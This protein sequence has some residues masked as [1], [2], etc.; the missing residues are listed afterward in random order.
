MKV[1]NC[2][3]PT[4]IRNKYSGE[5][6][7]VGCG[8]CKACLMKMSNKAAYLCQ[9]HEH[10]YKYCMFV[11]L[12]YDNENIPLMTYERIADSSFYAD[13][14][15]PDFD[16]TGFNSYESV[17]DAKRDFYLYEFNDCTPRL[18]DERGDFG[19]SMFQSYHSPFEMKML[20]SKFNLDG[21]FPYLN[22]R[23]LQLFIK[24]LRKQISRISNEK[25][26]HYSVGEYGPIHFRPHFHCLFYFNDEKIL[27]VFAQLVRSCWSFGRVDTQLSRG[28]CSSYVAKYVNSRVSVPRIFNH[29][30]VR[31]FALHSIHFA[32]RI[33]L[34]EKK[35]IYENAPSDF[36]HKFVDISSQ[37]VELYPWRS[38]TSLFFPK[39]KGYGRKSHDELSFTYRIL[40]TVRRLFGT[41]KEKFP[42]E[43]EKTISELA[44]SVVNEIVRGRHDAYDNINLWRKYTHSYVASWFA[45]ELNIVDLDELHRTRFMNGKRVLNDEQ[46]RV[47]NGIK[48][49]LYTSKHFLY[50]VCDNLSSYEIARKID[51]IQEFYEYVDY[52]NLVSWYQMQQT[53][54]ESDGQ[55]VLPYF[56]D[57]SNL[58][59]A[60]PLFSFG[61]Y[62]CFENDTNER[63]V[64]SIKHKQLNDLNNIF[65]DVPF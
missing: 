19:V 38:V 47:L 46:K 50:F 14:V 41:D 7:T 22:K 52:S 3:R 57:N 48:S 24:R 58:D 40:L 45:K 61:F 9:I 42:Y 29:N 62:K 5:M 51:K 37:V 15:T 65:C 39:C 20:A 27:Q 12:T 26:T 33:Y 64:R 10:D 28:K 18:M 4:R 32:Q 44:E 63:F 23:D 6:L 60:V 43:E 17:D 30:A 11:T 1:I 59:I 2:L 16:P 13:V 36:V 49:I 34:R 54:I 8:T 55:E 21:K 56:Y 35:E 31:P 53:V 25:I